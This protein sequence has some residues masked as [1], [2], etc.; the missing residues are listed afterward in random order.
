VENY[1]GCHSL[2][3][4]FNHDLQMLLE[5]SYPP[6]LKRRVGGDW[7]HL[8]NEQAA[9]LLEQIDHGMMRHLVVAHVSENNN[10]RLRTEAALLSVRPSLEG[11]V[12]ADQ[13]TGFDWLS[14]D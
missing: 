1:R 8:N 6:Q 10:C 2:L 3:L 4:E 11:V 14:L 7:G 5:G 12:W 13:R 9:A